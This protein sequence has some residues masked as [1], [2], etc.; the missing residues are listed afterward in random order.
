MQTALERGDLDQ[1][2]KAQ[3]HLGR[4][5]FDVRF[6]PLRIRNKRGTVERRGWS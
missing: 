3:N 6:N 4:L 5:G 1:A 2:A